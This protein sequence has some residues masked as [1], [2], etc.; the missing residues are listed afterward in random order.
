MNK[1][2]D[3]FT[4]LGDWLRRSG[5][6]LLALAALS[7]GLSALIQW[8][9]EVQVVLRFE[10]LAIW[11]G[12]VWQLVTGQLVHLGW[13]HL[14]LNLLGLLLV[15][16]LFPGI[17]AKQWLA[18]VVATLLLAGTILLGLEMPFDWYVGLSGFL[19]GLLVAAAVYEGLSEDKS[20]HAEDAW[21]KVAV[22]F[23]VTLKVL[24]EHFA[25]PLPMTAELA[26]G[27]VAIAGHQA[28]WVAGLI[29]GFIVAAVEG[30]RAGRPV[31]NDLPGR[32]DEDN[33]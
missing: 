2:N 3:G 5:W 33:S 28:G 21:I 6:P 4:A 15:A 32:H 11:G 9:P 22:L 13:S 24:W 14:G 23:V 27:P 8:N 31:G 10:P 26:E 19:H 16:V 30:R 17:S 25:G 18:L 20:P 12:A 1:L 29:A 7:I